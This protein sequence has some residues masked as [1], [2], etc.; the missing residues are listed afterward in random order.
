MFN[1]SFTIAKAAFENMSTAFLCK[2]A[3]EADARDKGKNPTK[4]MQIKVLDG[5]A[6]LSQENWR[7]AAFKLVNVSLIDT[8]ALATLVRP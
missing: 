8:A 6:S 1:I 3:G 7:D 4:T 5:L 2:Y